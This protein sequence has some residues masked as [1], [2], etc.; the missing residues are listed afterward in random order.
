M[1]HKYH[2]DLLV[3]KAR[4]R[5]KPAGYTERHH[6]VPKC[7]GG[8][9]EKDNLAVLTGREHFIAHLLLAHIHGG[10]LWYAL[11]KM[12]KQVGMTNSRHYE[13]A[14]ERYSTVVSEKMKGANN[15]RHRQDVKDKTS[16]ENHPMKR[17]EHFA[18]ISGENHYSRRE[19]YKPH[20]LGDKNP[21]KRKDI[22]KKVSDGVRLNNPL[23][24]KPENVEKLKVS[25]DRFRCER[26]IFVT[27]TKY[28][29]DIRQVTREMVDNFLRGEI[30]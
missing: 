21:M 22:V 7:L 13:L 4:S 27:E 30:K 16:G 18:K 2:Y 5:S 19:G 14:R 6:I 20:N 28:E 12:A 10:N 15:P 23:R 26:E 1:N 24:G 29:G 9:D 17:P 25:L 8:S 11:I 3:A